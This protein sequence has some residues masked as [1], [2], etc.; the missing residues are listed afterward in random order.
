MEQ[1]GRAKALEIRQKWAHQV[2]RAVSS[3]WIPGEVKSWEGAARRQDDLN[4]ELRGDRMEKYTGESESKSREAR[5]FR[6]WEGAGERER[7]AQF[8]DTGTKRHGEEAPR[9]L[10]F[11]PS[12]AS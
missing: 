3:K 9:Q 6:V 8:K 10:R 1:A 4:A 5:G 11:N 2:P 12:C 7:L